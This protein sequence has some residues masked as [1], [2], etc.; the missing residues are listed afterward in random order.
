M[1]MSSLIPTWLLT[2]YLFAPSFSSLPPA[3]IACQVYVPNAFS[4]NGD[5]V[6][7]VF[8]VQAASSCSINNFQLEIYDRWG[9]QVFQAGSLEQGWDGKFKGDPVKADLY[10]YRLSYQVTA[11]STALPVVGTGELYVLR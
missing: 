4:P 2:F 6:N 1:N 5:G 9:A 11:D 7:D 10:V 8:R 3:P